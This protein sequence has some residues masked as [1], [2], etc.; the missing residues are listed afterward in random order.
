[1]RYRDFFSDNKINI[2]TIVGVIKY[3]F[4]SIKW[5]LIVVP[6]L[7]NKR[8]CQ[9][10]PLFFTLTMDVCNILQSLLSFMVYKTKITILYCKQLVDKIRFNI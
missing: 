10:Y 6:N 4:N 5:E 8:S 9:H 2:K 3:H 7:A 1:M